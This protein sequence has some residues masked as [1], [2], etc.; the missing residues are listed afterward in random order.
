[1]TEPL[2]RLQTLADGTAVLVRPLL[3][4]DRL[5]IASAFEQLSPASRRKRFI[6][7][8]EHLND[9]DLEYLTNIDYHD[10]F[11]LVAF[12]EDEPGR[13][14]IA[15]ARYIRDPQDAEAAEVAVT[16]IDSHQRRGVGTLLLLLLADIAVHRGVRTFVSYVR[17]DNV[18]A[19]AGLTEYGARIH[20]DEPGVARVE[21]DLPDPVRVVDD[22]LARRV[23]TAFARH[24]REAVERIPVV[25]SPFDRH[26]RP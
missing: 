17:W 21:I 7:P 22:R 20:P 19:V 12:A 11:A 25:A 9:N 16:V 6:S 13:P 2:V 24:L 15:V 26:R 14:G 10:H 8:P 3:Y 23:L 18:G 1:L 5:E 4:S